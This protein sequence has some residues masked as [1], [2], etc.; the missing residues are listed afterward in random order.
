MKSNKNFIIVMSF[1]GVTIIGLLIVFLA[2]PNPEPGNEIDNNVI[3][4]PTPDGDNEK[5]DEN[6]KPQQ[7]NNNNNN[8]NKEDI[9]D[10][11]TISKLEDYNT[12]FTL[13][14]IVSSYYSAFTVEDYDKIMGIL[15]NEYRIKNNLKKENVKKLFS[16][17][18]GELSYLA[19]TI[20]VKENS[21][22]SYYF[23]NGDTL[24][25]IIT[26]HS[27][28][29]NSTSYEESSSQII[30]EEKI[31]YLIIYDKLNKTYSITPL[32]IMADLYDYAQEY[33]TKSKTIT[34]NT[35]NAFSITNQ[36][37]EMIV[38]RYISY[39]LNIMYINTEKAFNM[40]EANYKNSFGTLQNFTYNLD[41]INSKIS[42]NFLGYNVSGENGNRTYNIQMRNNTRMIITEEGI[43]NIKTSIK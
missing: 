35:Y 20:Y 28:D 4:Q 33:K 3:N 15:D 11:F 10:F 23:I 30:E 25:F 18:K 17:T 38:R 14:N 37:D 12:F 16:E 22:I 24:E 36:S 34:K 7:D 5:L 1:I 26:E 27:H 43:M 6:D 40:L 21:K 9:A 41:N 29:E 31:C 19:K 32:S 2:S 8:N 39:F 42:T 13:N